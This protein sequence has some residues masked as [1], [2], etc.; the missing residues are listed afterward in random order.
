MSQ[1]GTREGG[2]RRTLS[3]A[4]GTKS[5]QMAARCACQACA[6]FRRSGGGVVQKE[7]CD[8]TLFDGRELGYTSSRAM[9]QEAQRSRLIAGGGHRKG[10]AGISRMRGCQIARSG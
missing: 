6:Q 9:R 1:K 2:N 5:R 4:R 8:T 3:A 10:D 7:I